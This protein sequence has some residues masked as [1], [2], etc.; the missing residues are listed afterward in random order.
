MKKLLMLTMAGALSLGMQAQTGN[1]LPFQKWAL[2][3][4]MG[5]NSW[6]CYGPTV[7]ESEVKAN[8]DYMAKHLA[9]YGWE[10]V[11]VDIRWFVENDKAGGYNQTDPIYVYDEYGRYTPALNRFPSAANGVGF[12]ALADYVHGLGLKFGIHIMRGLPKIAAEKKLPVKGTNGITCDMIASNDSACTW[13]RDNYKVD[14]RKPGAQEY[15]NSIFDLYAQWGVDFVKVDDLSRPYHTAEIEMIRHAIDQCGRPIVLS[16]SPG[17]TPLEKMEHVKNHANMWRTVDD[18]WDNWSQLNYQFNVCAKWAPY[19]A[20]GTWPDADMLPLGKISIRGERGEERWTNFTTDEQYTMMNLWTIFKSPLMFGGDLPQNDE[21]TNKLLTDPDVLYMHHYSANNRQ[22]NRND[23][24]IIW[25]A[26]DPAN[27]DKF[28][29][30]FN[31]GGSSFV[32]PKNVLYRSGTIS[33]L[34][35]GYATDVAV[36]LPENTRQLAL[37]VTDGGDGYDCDHADW[38]NPTVTLKDGSTIKLT[39][40]TY[41]RGT[42]GWGSIHVNQNIEGGTLSINGQTYDNGFAVHANSILLFDLPEGAEKFTAFAGLDNTGTD[43]GSKSSVEFM[44]FNED[45]TIRE[46][47]TDQWNGGNVTIKVDPGKQVASSG[48]IS[49]NSQ[50]E[51]VNLSADITGAEKLYLVVTN[52]GDGLD[53]DHANWVNPVLVDADG[54]ETSL[55]TIAWDENP[56]NGWSSPQVNKN[57]DGGALTINGTTYDKGFGVNAPSVLTFTLPEGHQYKTFKALVGYDGGVQNADKGVTMEFRVFTQDPTPE[58]AEPVMLD[59]TQLGFAQDQECR[60]TDMWSDE[61]QGVFK[62]SE[63]APTIKAHASGLYRIEA[64]ERSS[65]ASVSIDTDGDNHKSDE[66]F[67]ITMTVSGP[68]EGAYV[69]LLCDGKI[70]GTLPVEADGTATY[71]C[72]DYYGGTYKF[73]AKYSGTTSV[74]P[75]ISEEVTVTIEGA[76]ADLSLLQQQLTKLVE[77]AKTVELASVAGA[78]R[79]PL[80]DALKAAEPIEGKD[81]AALETAI[82]NLETALDNARKSMSAMTALKNAVSEATD[83]LSAVSESMAKDELAATINKGDETLACE[84]ATT[85][86]VETATADIVAQLRIAK[87]ETAPVKGQSYDMTEFLTNPSF[88]SQTT[89]WT[90]DKQASGWEAYGTWSDR[91]AA[92]GTYFVSVVNEKISSLDLYQEVDGL[93]AGRYTVTGA[94]RNTD[95]ADKL[96]D[97]HVYAQAGSQT[98]DSDPLTNVSGEN[99]NDWSIL[100]ADGVLVADGEALRIGVR[101]TGDGNSSKGWFQADD[102]QLTYWGSYL[103]L[104]EKDEAQSV[105]AK[106]MPM[107]VTLSRTFENEGWNTL[108]LP[109][110]LDAET[111]AKYFS[112]IRKIESLKQED[113]TCVIVFSGQL[114]EIEAG[115]PY[116]VKTAADIQEAMAFDN[117]EVKSQTAADKAVTVSDDMATVTMKGQ[118]GSGT[119]ADGCFVLQGQAFVKAPAGSMLD[120]FRASI[121]AKD[122]EGHDMEMIKTEID[123][124]ITGIS[125][126]EMTDNEKVDVY[127]VAGELIKSNVRQSEATDNLKK[128]VYIING[129]KVIKN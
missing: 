45:P 115:V 119:L 66:P 129:K 2:T 29:A 31:T 18:F 88:E 61:E 57:N 20:P 1:E 113:N 106:D 78:C 32:N 104:D 107:N 36:D 93:P 50:A 124:I 127:T 85:E 33:Y 109:F 8:A 76:S 95:G 39:E 99:N 51:G 72:K 9:D 11:V 100:N 108:C 92:D 117:V 34:T 26:D 56:V 53:Y 24:R 91:P 68:A 52:G 69:Q 101:S 48:F 105:I 4:P 74:S 87:L 37:V 63:F 65:G 64:V 94:L 27:G 25:A 114:T 19:I 38:I 16:I 6:D 58:S 89:G 43:Q 67:N 59:L 121:L 41:L 79:A 90:L 30:L 118:Y 23:N 80:S 81:K 21:A 125:L 15:Y 120:G 49:R 84:T 17:E 111:A 54:K 98:V 10:Y 60:I 116:I 47:T 40:K 14:Y 13:L 126:T 103:T 102:F 46:E 44:V 82:S 70:V 123:G 35:T 86:E 3:P 62:N 7:V 110:S 22:L 83:F 128:G 112:D 12:K 42:C 71:V 55:T 122:Q 96:T 75:A 97:Q 77:D 5:W 73:Q 28:V